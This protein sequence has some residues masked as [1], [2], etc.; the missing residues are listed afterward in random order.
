[1]ETY[2]ISELP[3]LLFF[4]DG[5]M[6]GKVEGYYDNDSKEDFFEKIKEEIETE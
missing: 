3:S 6:I 5:E 1:M 4:K 2:G